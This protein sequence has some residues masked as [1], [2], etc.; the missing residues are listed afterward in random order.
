VGASKIS[1]DDFINLLTNAGYDLTK[2]S[3]KNINE[4]IHNIT[5]KKAAT[6]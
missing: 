3:K 5:N 4:I 6:T 2:L 1:I